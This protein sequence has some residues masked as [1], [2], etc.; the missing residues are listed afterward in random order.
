[1]YIFAISTLF[2]DSL[3]IV[4][5]RASYETKNLSVSVTPE[6]SSTPI[7]PVHEPF[8]FPSDEQ[9]YEIEMQTSVDRSH[10]NK[11]NKLSDLT[12]TEDLTDDELVNMYRD[13]E[14]LE[15]QADLLHYLF[16]NK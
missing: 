7:S 10:L 15:E 4:N 16:Y 3:E 1:M 13:S 6:N 14:I 8:S 9:T 12:I 5:L 2:I 11:I